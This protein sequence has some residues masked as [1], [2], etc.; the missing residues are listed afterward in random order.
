MEQ[1]PNNTLG[2]VTIAIMLAAVVAGGVAFT[3]SEM[4]QRFPLLRTPSRAK[5]KA[6]G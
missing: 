1:N 5:K 2:A 4:S 3:T 6:L